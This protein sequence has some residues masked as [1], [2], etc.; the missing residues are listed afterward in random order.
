MACTQGK[1][2]TQLTYALSWPLSIKFLSSKQKLQDNVLPQA[3]CLFSKSIY[4][5]NP[6]LIQGCICLAIYLNP[7]LSFAYLRIKLL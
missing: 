3:A 7:M 6:L 4:L 5:L 2:H 1:Q